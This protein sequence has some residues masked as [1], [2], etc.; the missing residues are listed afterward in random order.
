MYI[1]GRKRSFCRSHGSSEHDS[2]ESCK[3]VGQTKVLGVTSVT[4]RTLIKP[5]K[6]NDFWVAT[7]KNPALDGGCSLRRTE[8]RW[9]RRARII[10]TMLSMQSTTKHDRNPG[11]HC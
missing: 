4:P 2:P 11:K 7:F 5:M 10:P 6:F 3:N 9:C 1:S 8:P